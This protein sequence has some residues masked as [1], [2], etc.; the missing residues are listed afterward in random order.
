[1]VFLITG[2]SCTGKDTLLNNIFKKYQDKFEKVIPYTTRPIRDGEIDGENY[3]F[4]ES[5]DIVKMINKNEILEMRSYNTEHGKWYYLTKKFD[6]N[7]DKNY[8]CITT[9]EAVNSF[10]KHFNEQYNVKVIYLY[11]DDHERLLRCLQREDSQKFPNYVEMCRRFVEDTKDFKNY[12]VPVVGKK[13]YYGISLD[14]TKSQDE[15]VEDF[16]EYADYIRENNDG[17]G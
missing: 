7:H 9:L 1:M 14:A 12:N 6:D 2:K 16:V 8:V 15:L 17:R 13:T 10:Y 5:S 11:L 3:H 4:I